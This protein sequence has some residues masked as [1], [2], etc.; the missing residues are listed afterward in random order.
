MPLDYL[1]ESATGEYLTARFAGMDSPALASA[2]HRRTNGNPLYV[3]CLVDD[4]ERYGGID[5][6]P[7]T[8]R[9]N[10]ASCN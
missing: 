7:A 4:L 10:A 5:A 9:R 2:L 1:S 8:S 6:D 3:V